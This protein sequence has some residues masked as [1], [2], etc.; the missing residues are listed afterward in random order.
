MKCNKIQC[1]AI[2]YTHFFVQYNT[3][4]YNTIQ[5]NTIKYNTVQYN[6]IQYNTIQYNTIQ[7]N[8]IQYNTIQFI[9]IQSN[10]QEHFSSTIQYNTIQ[11]NELHHAICMAFQCDS[12]QRERT[13]IIQYSTLKKSY[14][15][16]PYIFPSSSESKIKSITIHG[17]MNIPMSNSGSVSFC[18]PICVILFTQTKH[19]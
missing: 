6:T 2:Q 10:R 18:I 4:Q 8:T 16:P 17:Q 19:E 7:Y 14:E 13:V 9:A 3:I 1:N 15:R 5:Y 11:Y 12:E